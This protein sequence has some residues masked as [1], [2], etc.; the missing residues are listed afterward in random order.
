MILIK[1]I[2]KIIIEFIKKIFG[3]K[4]V[5]K[6]IKKNIK[7]VKNKH[8]LKKYGMYMLGAYNETFP[9]YLMIDDERKSVLL[10]KI[11]KIKKKSFRLENNEQLLKEIDL[12]YKTIN[13]QDISF[14][15]EEKIDEKIDSLLNDKD[16]HLNTLNKVENVKSYIN[17]VIRDFDKNIKDK[18]LM[19]YNVVN[20]VTLSTV[21]IDETFKEL[22]KLEE[23][24][25]DH[26]YNKF[27]YDREINK[28]K[29]RINKLYKLRDTKEVYKEIEELRRSFYIK[30][31]DKYDL[32]YNGEI[33]ININSKCDE[34]LQKVNKRVIDIKKNKESNKDKEEKDN[35]NKD[36]YLKESIIKRF[37]DIELAMKIIMLNKKDKLELLDAKDVFNYLNGVYYDFL[38]GEKVI[39]NY[40]RNKTKTE[41]VKF[42]NSLN[43]LNAYMDNEE[44]IFIRHINYQMN[45]LIEQTMIK[46]QEL[47]KKLEVKYHYIKNKHEEGIL[48]DN[49]LDILKEEEEKRLNNNTNSV[50]KKTF[51][52]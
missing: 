3:K 38:T 30:S 51:N 32:L 41:L 14:Y 16:F 21:L 1:K 48:I 5:T 7:D 8:Y 50:L 31:K 42:Y 33:F 35:D 9:I 10:N 28:I 29:A 24:Y 47:E 19:E 46:K 37:Q 15:Q 20:Y 6:K 39:F 25:K 11:Q 22:K 44:Y 27:Y 23:D 40:E 45:D 18:V 36:E 49:K 4:K 43:R 52:S 13:Y 12:L 34:L 17:E 26:K 2:I